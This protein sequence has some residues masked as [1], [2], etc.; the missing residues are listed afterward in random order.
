M[1]FIILI[2]SDFGREM[3][4]LSADG[5]P[6]CGAEAGK[7]SRL[8]PPRHREVSVPLPALAQPVGGTRCLYPPFAFLATPR[9]APFP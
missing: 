8:D 3:T 6:H 5:S 4:P 1:D 7:A 2:N 9:T